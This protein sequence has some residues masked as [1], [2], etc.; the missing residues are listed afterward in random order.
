MINNDLAACPLTPLPPGFKFRFFRRGESKIW[1]QITTQAGEFPNLPAALK[2]FRREF[3]QEKENLF[4]RCIFLETTENQAVGTA[5]GWYNHDFGDGFYGRLHWVAII[6]AYQ[7]RGLARPLISQALH[8]IRQHHGK[9]YLSTGTRSFKA[10]K[11][12]LDYGFEPFIQT[13]EHRRGWRLIEKILNTELK[14]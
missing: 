6:P 5:M 8:I 7:G 12:Y 1:A 11:L 10:I 3:I 4:K 14:L 9:A 13:K 2:R